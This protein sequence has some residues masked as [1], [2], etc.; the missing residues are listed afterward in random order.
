MENSPTPFILIVDREGDSVD[1]IS[2]NS[3]V[4]YVFQILRARDEAYPL[5]APHAAWEFSKNKGGYSCLKLSDIVER[6]SRSSML[7][8]GPD[9]HVDR[10]P[11]FTHMEN[12]EWCGC[13]RNR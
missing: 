9:E 5:D 13:R 10:G 8:L 6:S 12:I 2:A 4:D 11:G 1:V 7:T 3:V